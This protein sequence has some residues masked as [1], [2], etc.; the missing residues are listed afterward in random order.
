MRVHQEQGHLHP[1]ATAQPLDDAIL[2][3][4]RTEP[5][6][7]TESLKGRVQSCSVSL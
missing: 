6:G 1:Q 3:S 7:K 2:L 5:G 4:R